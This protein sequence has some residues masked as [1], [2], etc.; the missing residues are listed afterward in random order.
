MGSK[1]IIYAES[2]DRP[3]EVTEPYIDL[4]HFSKDFQLPVIEPDEQDIIQELNYDLERN[5]CFDPTYIVDGNQ[6]LYLPNSP[7]VV[8]RMLER[9]VF[10]ARMTRARLLKLD[11]KIHKVNFKGLCLEFESA[12]KISGADFDELP[13]VTGEQETIIFQALHLRHTT[14]YQAVFDA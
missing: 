7:L 2:L 8:L 5:G 4:I 11:E 12:E 14:P 13:D 9:N 10:L 3:M 6:A 1:E